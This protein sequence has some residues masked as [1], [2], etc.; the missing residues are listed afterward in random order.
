MN[1]RHARFNWMTDA[2]LDYGQVFVDIEAYRPEVNYRIGAMAAPMTV[3]FEA[4]YDAYRQKSGTNEVYLS[5][6][7]D[8]DGEFGCQSVLM[9]GEGLMIGLAML[10][11]NADGL[12]TPEQ[13][14]IFADCLPHV[15]AGV[16]LQNA[17]DH[18]GTELLRGSL[19]MMRTAAMMVDGAGRV[20]AWTRPAEDVLSGGLLSIA[21]GQLQAA[22]SGFDAMLQR[23][24]GAAIA[25][26]PV[27]F[28]DLWVPHAS[29]PLLVEVNPLPLRPWSFGFAPA[30]IITFRSPLRSDML[31]GAVLA[32]ALGLTRA[33]GDVTAMVAM[34]QSRQAIAAVRCTSVQ[35]VTAQMRSIFQKCGVRREA[36]LVAI[37]LQIGQLSRNARET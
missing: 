9:R 27:P 31:D 16:R 8:L 30:A 4:D 28:P 12:S 6:A 26:Q 20:C 23:A 33:E 14:A 1:D 32:Q 25:S 18:Q 19:D 7:R 15:L 10:H 3:T 37:A 21:G 22:H 34:G 13:R 35:T 17:I 29:P 5:H 24:V 2:P 11:G 36:E